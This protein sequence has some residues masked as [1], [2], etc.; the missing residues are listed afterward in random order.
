M[1]SSP[2][3]IRFTAPLRDVVLGL[4][5][6]PPEPPPPQID[7][8]ALHAAYEKGRI[9]GEKSL[10]EQLVQQRAEIQQLLDGVVKS[11][12][13]AVAQVVTDTEQHLVELALQIAQKLVSDVAI[14]A[15]MVEGVVRDALSEVEGSSE[16]LVRLHPEDFQL[17]EKIESPLLNPNE[18]GTPSIRFQRT[19]EVSRGGCVVQTRFGV[20]DARRE[21]RMEL[22]KRSLLG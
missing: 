10:G 1:K 20:I 9:E 12:Q 13:S 4:V 17:L 6:P 2:D 16:F 21:T 19:P 8:A 3:T 22:L 11:L 14:T 5:A 15:E 7:E 18:D